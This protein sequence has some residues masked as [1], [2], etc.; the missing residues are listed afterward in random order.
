MAQ[1]LK[2]TPKEGK[3]LP[4]LNFIKSNKIFAFV[5]ILL[6]IGLC[7]LA[8]YF[9]CKANTGRTASATLWHDFKMISLYF[10]GLFSST[11]SILVGKFNKWINE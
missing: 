6:M 9:Q 3:F 5:I 11:I 2:D 1:K 10:F 8:I 7:I 4:I